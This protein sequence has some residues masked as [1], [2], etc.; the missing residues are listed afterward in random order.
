[1]NGPLGAGADEDRAMP[2]G[3]LSFRELASP[4]DVTPELRRALAERWIDATTAGERLRPL[5]A[6]RR[7]PARGALGTT[8]SLAPGTNRLLSATVNGEPDGR[9]NVPRALLEPTAYRGVLQHVQTRTAVRGRGTGTALLGGVRRITRNETGLEQFR[10]AARGG[11]GP[12]E[13]LQT[14]GWREVG[15][16]PRCAWAPATIATRD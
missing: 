4:T 5:P 14:A 16:W 1:M 13:L 6:R 10:P 2:G 9:L 3:L 11:V 8:G 15:R 7:G 12:E